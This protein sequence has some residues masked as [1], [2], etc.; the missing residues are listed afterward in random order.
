MKRTAIAKIFIVALLF[1]AV[2]GTQLVGLGNGNPYFWLEEVLPDADTK[3]PIVSIFS[4]INNTI[5]NPNDF[6]L[7]FNVTV[8]ESKTAS[9]TCIFYVQYTVDWLDNTTYFYTDNFPT[10][11][12]YDINL[13]GVREG[14]HSIL[15][16]AIESGTYM[17]NGIPTYAFS[18]NSSSSVFFTIDASFHQQS[19]PFPTTLVI[20]TIASV[21]V[22]GAGVLVYFKKRKGKQNL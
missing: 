15:V 20:A 3:P 1:S 5:N 4:P 8:G 16:Y 7:T 21:A 13:T 10:H 11:F 12:S 18:I 2:A 14:N 17:R 9:E 6:A 19:E 22:I